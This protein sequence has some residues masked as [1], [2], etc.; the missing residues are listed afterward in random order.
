MTGKGCGAAGSPTSRRS[1]GSPLCCWHGCLV[2]ELVVTTVRFAGDLGV[3]A[4]LDHVNV[5]SDNY[6]EGNPA[7]AVLGITRTINWRLTLP[8]DEADARLRTAFDKIGLNPEGE[9]GHISG[10]SKT[11]IVKNRWSAKVTADVAPHKSGSIVALCVEMPVGTKHYAV[12]SD[13]AKEVGDDAFDDRGLAAAADRLRGFSKIS[14]RLELRNVRNYL[15]AT[16]TVQ[17]LGQGVWGGKQGLIVLTDERLFFF[18][19]ALIGA[20]VEEFP[21]DAITSIVVKKKL[22]G[23]ALAITV[24]GNVTDITGMAHGQGDALAQAFRRIKADSTTLAA[25]H[26]VP[27][28]VQQA[29]SSADELAKFAQMHAQGILTDE[30]FAAAK[31]RALGM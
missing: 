12:A 10:K 2:E 4:R 6:G 20:T 28:I 17:E 3:W 1:V 19:K 29:P 14:G 21:L 7:M 16:E 22:T 9:P 31:K 30:E 11:N 25:G 24:A 5:L 18:D 13:V 26:M 27:T 15:T 8:P 23:E